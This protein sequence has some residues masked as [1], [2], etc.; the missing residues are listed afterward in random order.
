VLNGSSRGSSAA[1][2]RTRRTLLLCEITLAVIL[3][4]ATGL[5]MRSLSRLLDVRPGFE[6][7]HAVTV[8]VALPAAA[9]P[10]NAARQAFVVEAERRLS[11][12]PGVTAAGA[13]S[14]LPLTGSGPLSPY[15]YNEQTARAWESLTAD[16]RAISPGYFAAMGTQLIAGRTFDERDAR[17]GAPRV[18]IVDRTIAARA[19]PGI[20]PIGR[21][22]Q[23]A[24]NPAP[25]S[26]AEVVGVVENVRG[27]DIR[28]EIRGQIYSPYATIGAPRL[29]FVVRT[30]E[31]PDRLLRTV[32]DAIHGID[33]GVPAVAR[34]LGALVIDQLAEVR[35]SAFLLAMF[36][37]IAVVLVAVGLYGVMSYTVSQRTREFGIRLALG[38]SAG[39]LSR[40]IF[41]DTARLLALGLAIGTV[42]AYRLGHV[43]QSLVFG[44]STYD[45]SLIVGAAAIV[46]SLVG[47]LGAA[48][49]TRAAIRVSPLEAMRAE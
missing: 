4:I 30:T 34:P 48:F 37:T 33:A 28:R 9:Y 49:P 17:P 21:K 39:R 1:I 35:F 24:P 5:T 23:V 22:L 13:T 32:E 29:A 45:L 6:P 19:W 18:I 26:F 11:E 10:N 43:A 15:A 31:D 38:E 25:E 27:E 7:E 20:D 44:V 40:G 46:I 36:G 8:S 3:L 41:A 12:I 47:F 42:I 2:A 16:G 14:Q